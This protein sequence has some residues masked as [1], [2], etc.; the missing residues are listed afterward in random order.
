MLLLVP[1]W[2][3]K[4]LEGVIVAIAMEATES[5][6][7]SYW[8][9]R[10]SLPFGLLHVATAADSLVIGS[11]RLLQRGLV[12]ILNLQGLTVKQVVG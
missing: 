11:T 3:F 1:D 12:T 6:L 8:Q 2:G 4:Q 7:C 5:D 10:P 9:Q